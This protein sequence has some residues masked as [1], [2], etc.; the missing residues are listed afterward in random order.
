MNEYKV[1][2]RKFLEII[3]KQADSLEDALV[4]VFENFIEHKKT[5][6]EIINKMNDEE[7][8]NFPEDMNFKFHHLLSEMAY[9]ILNFERADTYAE[10]LF[11]YERPPP[12]G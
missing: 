2:K 1:S 8:E 12:R 10:D 7:D 4:A 11:A 6:E 9:K 3:G 5:A